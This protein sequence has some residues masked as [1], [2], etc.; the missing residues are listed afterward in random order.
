MRFLTP[1][2][3]TALMAPRLIRPFSQ[4]RPLFKEEVKDSNGSFIDG[5]AEGDAKG[6]TGGGEPLD[7]SSKNAP[8]QPKVSNQSIPGNQTDTL[9]EE[10]KREVEEHNRDFDEKHD[11]G[12]RAPGD[13]VDKKF[14][15]GE[16]HG[17][18][19]KGS[20]Q[21]GESGESK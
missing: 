3:P 1:L 15:A 17:E 9:T 13:K 16:R 18:K 6:R 21:P 4:A 5:L 8:P 2:R 7:A 12:N 20:V 10:Q 11:R 14:W 19:D